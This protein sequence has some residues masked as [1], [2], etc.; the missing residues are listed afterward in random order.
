MR[1]LTEEMLR[2]IQHTRKTDTY[3]AYLIDHAVIDRARDIA[4]QPGIR[5]P[6]EPQDW[7]RCL[8]RLG[9]AALACALEPDEVQVHA[10]LHNALMEIA[11]MPDDQ[12]IGPFFRPR[13]EPPQGMLET[14]TILVA[15]TLSL[16]ICPEVLNEDETALLLDQVRTVGLPYS[17]NWIRAREAD[18][19][20]GNN[21]WSVVLLCGCAYG[22]VLLEDMDALRRIVEPYNRLC[23]IMN[24]DFYGETIGYWSYAASELAS[25]RLLL[26]RVYPEMAKLLKPAETYARIL[27]WY[28]AQ[29]IGPFTSEALPD[30]PLIRLVNFS[31]TAAIQRISS[32]LLASIAVR[33]Q[34]IPSL[35]A[36][37]SWLFKKL[38]TKE[39]LYLPDE[40]RLGFWSTVT[41]WSVLLYPDFS[42]PCS[43]S[44]YPTVQ[45]FGDG[46]TVLRGKELLFLSRAG[47]SVPSRVISHRHADQGTIFAA[48][49]GVVLLDD[50]GS[51]CYRLPLYIE[52]KQDRVH[53]L[54][55]FRQGNH[56]LP[57]RILESSDANRPPLNRDAGHEIGENGFWTTSDMG[58]LYPDPLTKVLRTVW[59]EKDHIAFIADEWEATSPVH[60]ETKFVFNNR[61]MGM[62][63]RISGNECRMTREKVGVRVISL[64]GCSPSLGYATLHDANHVHPGAPTQGRQGNGYEITFDS[65]DESKTGCRRFLLVFDEENK[66]DQWQIRKEEDSW[67]LLDADGKRYACVHGKEIKSEKNTCSFR[68]Y[69]V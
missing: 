22:A 13:C 39:T 28:S 67:V 30:P 20:F 35:A 2:K 25:V 56:P 62:E 55:L 29:Y 1:I 33:K 31:D 59:A 32:T 66:L 50:P 61:N 45:R 27:P 64:D 26:E 53:S 46:L 52:G 9:Y 11:R 40:G 24:M 44:P 41:V 54:P 47:S 5:R 17:K 7:W 36:L 19:T 65:K 14:S 16:G 34:E 10:W 8:N 18:G 4:S 43:A 37:A 3:F 57:Q 68:Q 51:C 38:F 69:D 49:S 6:E 60:E 58:S 63:W 48:Y 15:V 42:A 21:N 23:E 12:W